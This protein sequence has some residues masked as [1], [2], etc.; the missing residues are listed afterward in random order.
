MTELRSFLGMVNQISSY[1]PHIA[2]HTGILQTLLKK[3][4]AFLRLYEQQ[5]AFDKLKNDITSALALNH[6]DV[7]WDSHLVTDASR[8]HGLGFALLQTSGTSTKLMQCGSRSLSQAERNYSMLELELTAIVW[9][10]HKCGFFLKG[11]ERFTVVT[12]HRPLV[13]LL[14][15]LSTKAIKAE[16]DRIPRVFG[17]PLS[18]RT[19]GGPQFRGTFEAYFKEQGHRSRDIIPI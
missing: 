12:D 16:I 6:F 14:R 15:N 11:I 13:G 9:A 8:L 10:I 18:C 5:S 17:I 3:D 4:V 19:D 2:R 7:T 1:H